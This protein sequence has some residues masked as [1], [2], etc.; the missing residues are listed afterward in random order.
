VVDTAQPKVVDSAALRRATFLFSSLLTAC[1]GRTALD[2]PSSDTSS[3]GAA[4]AEQGGRG[5]ASNTAGAGGRNVAGKGGTPAVGGAG[6]GAPTDRCRPNP[7]EQGG[8][9]L[10]IDQVAICSCPAAFTGDHCELPRFEGLGI[11][12]AS[13]GC[14]PAAISS[15]GAVVV[16]HCFE[17]QQAFR[18][19]RVSGMTRIGPSTTKAWAIATDA[20]GSVT[21]GTALHDECPDCQEFQRAFRS[22]AAA[23]LD[24]GLP[25]TKNNAVA[26]GIS[27]D[28]SVIVGYA[29][30]GLANDYLGFSW[31]RQNGFKLTGAGSPLAVSGDGLV[32]VGIQTNQRAVRWTPQGE[33]LE[34][35][36]L[37]G[38]TLSIAYAADADGSVIVG[39][40][41]SATVTTAVRWTEQNGTTSVAPLAGDSYAAFYATN[42]DGSIAVGV[43]HPIRPPTLVGGHAL[44][45]DEARGS[46]T[47]ESDLARAGV[48]IGGWQLVHAYAVSANG[49]VISGVGTNPSGQTEGWIA[50]LP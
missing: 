21:V 16:G 11:L 26:T 17:A 31:T 44:I 19:D 37:P 15:D 34:L 29:Y 42:G 32:T 30:G 48:D 13:T 3:S 9:C 28:A 50:R 10:T 8:Q 1:G 47:L 22:E 24:L 27:A 38:Q 18:W 33:A 46:R 35:D 6:G 39:G 49:R 23:L 25:E 7:C 14:V 2:H 43:S 36:A 45:W 5:G 20:R 40:S 41:W 4:G 12:P